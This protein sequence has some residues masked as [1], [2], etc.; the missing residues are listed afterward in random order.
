MHIVIRSIS[1]ILIVF[2]SKWSWREDRKNIDQYLLF[3]ISVKYA[4]NTNILDLI[5]L[6]VNPFFNDV[7]DMTIN[8][9]SIIQNFNYSI[10]FYFMKRSINLWH[11]K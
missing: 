5:L 1:N 6:K 11:L 4:K 3:L 8:I 9:T 10:C 2:N 7:N